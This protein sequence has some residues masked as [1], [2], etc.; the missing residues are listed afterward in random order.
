[1]RRQTSLAVAL[2]L[3][4]LVACDG[5]ETS[6]NFSLRRRVHPTP[7]SS[8]SRVIGF[9]GTM[10]G[11]EAWRGEDAFEGAD[12]AVH[13][14]NRELGGEQARFELVTLDDEGDPDRATDLVEELAASERTAGIIYAGPP[15]G[16]SPAEDALAEAGIPALLCYG[17]LYGARRLSAHVFQMAPSYVW[18][19][20]RLARYA[21]ED[22]RYETVGALVEDSLDG[23]TAVEA[24]R[25]ELARAGGRLKVAVT[26]PP[27]AEDLLSA[28]VRLRSNGIEAVVVQGAPQAIGRIVAAL[29]DMGAGYRDTEAARSASEAQKGRRKGDRSSSWAPQVLSFDG[30]ISPLVGEELPAGTVAADSYARGAYYLPV[31]SFKGF[32]NSFVDWWGSEP[33]GWELRG[34]EA[35]RMV[36]RAA[37]QA[38]EGG[39]V[40][41][42]LEDL[43]GARFGG[44]DITLGPDDHTSV[45]ATNVGLWVVPGDDADVF[46]RDELA[47]G[48]PWVPLARGFSIDGDRTDILPKDW[49]FLFRDPPPPSAPAPKL[50]RMRYGVTTPRSDPL[51]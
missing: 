17:D 32:E 13:V 33:T 5:G 9:V 25:A 2:S 34:Y 50:E 45:G 8:D 6:D 48:L 30:A 31:P 49:K 44:L 42:S 29:D 38:P 21:L 40:A 46:E 24:L 35:T 16:L 19:A 1:M 18:E 27:T 26:Y 47:E 7:T 15:A 37:S 14:I 20:R 22:R 23:R 4:A 10:S 43:E 51:H 28:L 11:P 12:V 39:D 3:L 36:A 41:H